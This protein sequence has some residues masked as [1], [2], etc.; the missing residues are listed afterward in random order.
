MVAQRKRP[1]LL[2][3]T[4]ALALVYAIVGKCAIAL[5]IPPGYATAIFPSAG[6]ALGAILVGGP[7][8]L[9]GVLIGSAILNTWIAHQQG[10]VDATTLAIAIA[11]GC[12]AAL[13]AFVGWMLIR[14]K[15]GY[16]N[17]L[18]HEKAIICFMGIAGP[19]GCLIGA[20]VGTATLFLFGIYLS[21]IPCFSCSHGG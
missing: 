14:R 16:P 13:Q 6:I 7:R 11:I 8:L 18:S 15:I 3:A 4:M 17:P 2:L 12:G 21:A 5:A 20:G 1:N 10:G 19:L 9:P